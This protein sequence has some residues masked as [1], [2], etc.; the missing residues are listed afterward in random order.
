[1]KK[2]YL[3]L[4]VAAFAAV[5]A[6]NIGMLANEPA[7]IPP[8]NDVPNPYNMVSDYFKLPAGRTWGS[9]STI[10]IDKDGKSIWIA[11]RCGANS[12]L[13]AAT[14]QIKDVATVMKF[15]ES[16]KLV[17]AFGNGLLVFPHGMH[18]DRDGNVWVTD[19]Q[20]NA[21]R[22]ARGA[23]PAGGGAGAGRGPAPTPGP[24]AG[25][26]K[27]HQVFKFSPDGKLLMTIGKPGGSVAPGEC[28][29]QPNDVITTPDGKFVFVAEGHSSTAGWTAKVLKFDASGKF[30]KEFGKWGNGDGD[31]DQPHA[32]AFDSKGMLYVG[33]RNN[34]R[35]QVFD[36]EG[37]FKEKFYQFSRPSGIYIDKDDNLYVAD[38]ESGSVSQNHQD[39]KRGIR[40]GSLKDKDKKVTA[41]IPDPETRIRPAFT[42]T[43]AAE[44]VVVDA[45]GNVYGAEVGPRRVSRYVK[46]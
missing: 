42:G 5:T 39:W 14:G 43:S 33:D 25:A 37:N 2:G 13:D 4:A 19:G 22:P 20:D 24:G 17:T 23:A 6:A 16:G 21:P 46:K 32:L 7:P 34:N 12:C 29:F 8:V 38:S 1:M 41:F 28:C 26:T 27:G 40:I 9:T 11:E 44:G 35:I 30:V 31:F 10:D 18:V 15:D 45:K 3:A 36:Q